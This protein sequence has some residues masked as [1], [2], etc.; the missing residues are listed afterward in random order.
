MISAITILFNPDLSLLRRQ[1]LIC[2]KSNVALIWVDNNS[3]LSKRGLIRNLAKKMNARLFLLEK[4]EGLAYGQNLGVS[5]SI[6]AGY[7]TSLILDQDSVP[8]KG[9]IKSLE[10]CMYDLIKNGHEVAAVGPLIYDSRSKC[11]VDAILFSYLSWKRIRFEKTIPHKIQKVSYLISSGTLLRNCAW[12][13]I[14]AMRNDL[15]IEFIDVEWGERAS[16]KGWDIFVNCGSVLE[17]V[18]ILV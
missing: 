16:S 17:A 15:F 10:L 6:S 5:E 4:N 8:T 2:K 9:M 7:S 1:A 14:G 12:I 3:I 13:E 18:S 11:Y